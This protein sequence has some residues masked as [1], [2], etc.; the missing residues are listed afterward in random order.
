MRMK[1]KGV[2]D[3]CEGGRRKGLSM[4]LTRGTVTFDLTT[5]IKQRHGSQFLSAIMQHQGSREKC[6]DCQLY[7]VGPAI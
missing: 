2:R 3:D 7:S 6:R 5:D 1:V 4:L